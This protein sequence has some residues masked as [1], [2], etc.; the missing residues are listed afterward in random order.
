[1]NTKIGFVIALAVLALAAGCWEGPGFDP[2]VPEPEPQASAQ[3]TAAALAPTAPTQPDDFTPISTAKLPPTHTPKPPP[4]D[5]AEPTAVRLLVWVRQE[6]AI[7]NPDKQPLGWDYGQ[8]Q[9]RK[10]S[11][12][13]WEVA[14]D[15]FGSHQRYQED[16]N[17][18]YDDVVI[19]VAFER[20]PLVLNP[21]LRY[22]L[23]ADFSH[24]S[25][26]LNFGYE[27]LGENFL[28]HV[29][30]GNLEPP[31]TFPYFP[32]ASN[33]DGTKTKEWMLSVPPPARPGEELEL[34]A[35]MMNWPPGRVIWKYVA[36][37]H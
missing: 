8:D 16:E 4:T 35:S 3:L 15:G 11:S 14:E 20:P 37:Y 1:M 7:V 19:R 24:S 32:F 29:N 33:F 21:Q 18:W 9:R 36:E 6:P 27:G 30:K 22:K 2:Y 10:N 13:S 12:V 31:G 23:R 5:T 34:S 25:G 17:I 26:A 28:W